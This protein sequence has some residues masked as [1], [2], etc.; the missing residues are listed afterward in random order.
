MCIDFPLR[1]WPYLE[2][3]HCSAIMLEPSLSSVT[4]ERSLSSVHYLQ[5]FSCTP[6]AMSRCFK[7]EEF[8]SLHDFVQVL[9]DTLGQSLSAVHISS[10]FT[11][12]LDCSHQVTV[13][14]IN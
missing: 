2:T 11:L 1:G 14:Y 12:K 4:L 3:K 5:V 7:Y 9:Q 10:C 6:S 8:C 13:L